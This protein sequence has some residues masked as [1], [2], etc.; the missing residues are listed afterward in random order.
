MIGLMLAGQMSAQEV[1]SSRVTIYNNDFGVVRQTR[2]IDIPSGSSEIRLT[3]VPEKIEAPSVKIKLKGSVSEQNFRYDLASQSSIL[4]SYIDK[5]ITLLP[6]KSGQGLISGTLL[7]F[8]TED[9]GD[10]LISSVQVVMRTDKGILM[11]P[12]IKDYVIEVGR[13]PDGMT[14][15]PTLIWKVQADKAGRQDVD[16]SY[17]TGGF[18]WQADYTATLNEKDDA[19]DL[20]SWV[21][22]TN[23]TGASFNDAFVKL[24]A[25]NVK[26]VASKPIM[27]N[28]NL[29][30]VPEYAEGNMM[31][32]FTEK[33]LFEYHTYDLNRTTDLLNHETKQ[34][35]LFQKENIKV[36][37]KYIFST[38]QYNNGT[39]LA[40]VNVAVEF[41]NTEKNG[42]GI[43]LP[44][45][46]MKVYKVQ[47]RVPEFVGEDRIEHT[48]KD[49]KVTLNIGQVFDVMGEETLINSNTI[50]ERIWEKEFS[51]KLKN[52]KSEDVT[53]EVQKY[54]GWD[55]SVLSSDLKYEQKDASTIVF[56][57]PVPK[58]SEKTFKLKVRVK[59]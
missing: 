8:S 53:I 48:P 52:R 57:V 34:I 55:S 49:E 31:A 43:P 39:S 24:M 4:K 10:G 5:N 18:S 15:V 38:S 35:E 32:S 56:K 3:D 45:G 51:I 44:M 16:L 23:E 29:R 2:S 46:V 20:N 13:L 19:I 41:L 59:M 27:K 30:E 37:K 9:R 54:I 42:L 12:D 33:P 14:T 28:I 11:I 50:T 7:N 22:I 26:K 6:G 36:V 40:P 17:I 25:G 21:T 58:D 47:E 1:K